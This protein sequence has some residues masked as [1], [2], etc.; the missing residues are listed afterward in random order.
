MN[1]GNTVLVYRFAIGLGCLLLFLLLSG[2]IGRIADQEKLS[3]R[4]FAVIAASRF[5]F[6]ACI[7]LLLKMKPHGDVVGYYYPQALSV[8]KGMVPYR[9]FLSSYGFLHPYLDAAVLSI[10]NNSFS[11]IFLSI[12]LEMAALGVW[13]RLAN[14]LI[15]EK[16]A[17]RPRLNQALLLYLCNT[18]SIF[19]IALDG[20]NN[21]VLALGIGLSIAFLWR[22]NEFASGISFSMSLLLAK[23]LP[24]IFFPLFLVTA[25]RRWKWIAGCALPLLLLCGTAAFLHLNVLQPFRLEGGLGI[26]SNLPYLLSAIA[27][28]HFRPQF[29]QAFGGAVL[30]LAAAWYGWKLHL[31]RSVM[32]LSIAS[33]GLLSL[34]LLL[35][36]KAWP[37]YYEILLFPLCWMIAG[38]RLSTRVWALVF[39]AVAGVQASFWF[40]VLHIEPPWALH[41]QLVMFQPNALLYLLLLTVL[42]SG[43]A[44]LALLCMHVMAK[45]SDPLM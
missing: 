44:L 34:L 30:L 36:P 40:T 6:F 39:F 18:I 15:Q 29:F 16:A 5:C 21:A 22:R 41:Q 26:E 32:G 12:V 14:D 9:D 35:A 43:N 7:F 4:L 19:A 33:I 3:R 24:L 11:L 25:R 27:G 37:V 31:C 1:T 20:T 38:L 2:P 17:L 10:H 8:M 28:M 45:K 23:F 13:Y 42:V